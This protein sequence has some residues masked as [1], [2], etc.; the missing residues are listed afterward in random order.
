MHLH[1]WRVGELCIL[2][3]GELVKR[4]LLW[5]RLSELWFVFCSG[6]E[7]MKRGFALMAT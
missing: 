7:W 2:S 1:W 5:W 3:G 6:V 4:G